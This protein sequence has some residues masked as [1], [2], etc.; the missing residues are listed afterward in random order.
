MQWA[1]A[2]TTCPSRRHTPLA[3]T[4]NSLKA[5]G[6]I[7]DTEATCPRIFVDGE[8]DLKGWSTQY[9]PCPVTIRT[10]PALKVAGSW[11]LTLYE[12]YIRNPKADRYAIFQDDFV[13]YRNLR[14]YLEKCK[15]PD[16]GDR[17]VPRGYWNLYTFPSNQE[18]A[19]QNKLGN[20]WFQSRQTGR[21]ALALIFDKFT[22]IKLLGTSYLVERFQD[23]IGGWRSIDGGIVTALKN[24]GIKEYTH[25]PSLVQH[26][27]HVSSFD[28]RKG[29]AGDDPNFPKYTWFQ[30]DYAKNFKGEQ[31]DA[32]ELLK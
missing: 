31:F 3:T 20:G 26:I 22:V 9:A 32:M 8:H 1:T 16:G 15:Y 18:L 23:L 5:A 25:N 6:F 28:K 19:D 17:R 13:T 30:S 12:L 11:V 7:G 29:V 24:V 10:P 4:I 21:G 27:G 2:I 14:Q